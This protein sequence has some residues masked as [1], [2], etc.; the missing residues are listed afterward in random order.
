MTTVSDKD[1]KKAAH[2]L[3]K[4]GRR[5]ELIE[6]FAGQIRAKDL[7]KLERIKGLIVTEDAPVRLQALLPFRQLDGARPRASSGRT[8]PA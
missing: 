8:S 2:E 1:A 5:F 7:E 3:K 6:G 4:L